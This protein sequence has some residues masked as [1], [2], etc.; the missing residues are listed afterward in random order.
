M[1]QHRWFYNTLSAAWTYGGNVKC[2]EHFT[3][4]VTCEAVGV[5]PGPINDKI[6]SVLSR[7]Q[8]G[9]N[10]LAGIA[11]YVAFHQHEISQCVSQAFR[12]V[13]GSSNILEMIIGMK[14]SDVTIGRRSLWASCGDRSSHPNVR[15][16]AKKFVLKHTAMFMGNIM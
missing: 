1:A 16:A 14:F 9:W 3:F 13:S 10:T 12:S 11:W 2:S 7:S 4:A 5:P 6:R 8:L 15:Y